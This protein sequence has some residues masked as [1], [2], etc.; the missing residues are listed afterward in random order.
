[1]AQEKESGAL[2][3]TV[4]AL[5]YENEENGYAVLRLKTESGVHV[6]VGCIP[7][8]APGE[9]LTLKGRWICHPVY[10]EQFQAEVVERT[11]PEGAPALLE[12]LSSGVIPGVGPVTAR[13]M[14]EQFGKDALDVLETE[15]ERLLELRGMTPKKAREIA[16]GYRRQ[17]GMRRLL[18]FLSA[19]ELPLYLGAR[20]YRRFGEMAMA[21]LT[22]NPYVLI[23]EEFGLEFAAADALALA[24]GLGTDAPVRLEAGL[25]FELTHNAGNGH[26]FLPKRKLLSAA[27]ALIGADPEDVA[28]GLGALLERGDVVAERTAGEEACYLPA[29]YEAERYVAD[30][31]LE[32]ARAELPGPE[33]MD[34]RLSEIARQQNISYAPQQVLAVETAAIRR[35]MLLT[36][37]PG[38]GKTTSVRGILALFDALGLET[39]LAAPTGRAA[40]RLGDVCGREAATIHRLLEASFD[41]VSGQPGFG[42]NAQDP[43]SADAI[44]VDETSMVDLLLFASLLRAMS[45]DCRLIL[46]GDPDQLP[47][48]GPGNLLSDLRRCG[49]VAEVRLSEIF[50]QSRESAIVMSAH[51]VN[52]GEC[53]DLTNR[54][55][56]FFFLRRREP[57]AA[58][59]TVVELCARRLP[60]N[61]GIRP[62]QIQVLSPTRR[63]G[64]GT[65]QLNR[66]LQ[67]ALNPP[68][69]G[70]RERSFGPYLFREGDRVMQIRNNYNMM[71]TKRDGT[72][73][74]MGIFNG[75]IGKILA[76]SPG[77]GTVTV[78]F[79]DR[80]ADYAEDQLSELEP[81]YAMTV[82]KAQGSEYRAVVLLALEG[83]PMLRTR[84]VLYTAITRARELLII[85]GDDRVVAQ[86]AENNL[87]RRRYSGLRWRLAKEKTER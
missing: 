83:A 8:A 14:L 28:D 42:K 23:E 69:E 45:P 72:E 18:E 39:V 34:E 17:S 62:E 12:Y 71:W 35:I 4:N 76:I 19:H 68:E 2:C 37:G 75:D 56:D 52:R 10:G 74:G 3:G 65:K 63:Y 70:K 49:Q 41:S 57:E 81:A 26:S 32:M 55:R 48:V 60:Q 59:A 7:S 5:I 67:A 15:P 79:E 21:A 86:M 77:D 43:I 13:R 6:A 58:A 30:R 22:D 47:S 29:L 24:L 40:K 80:V 25:Q 11:L 46:V 64:T 50:R 85:V 51:A 73:A 84:G 9:Q 53:P 33:G 87:P 66:L 54:S 44:I 82:H 61:M 78:E 16:G 31:V 20:L 36:G 38:T 27:A 1:M